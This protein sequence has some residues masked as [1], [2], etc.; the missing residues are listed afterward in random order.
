[1]L[2][3]KGQGF[4]FDDVLLIPRKSSILPAQV[5]LVT[6]LGGGVSLKLPVLSA[7]MDTVTEEAMAIAVAT[8]GG[9]GV[10]HR[11]Q[12]I[13]AQAKQVRIVKRH[14]SGVVREPATT[15][16]HTTIAELRSITKQLG[17]SGMPVVDDDDELV[18]IVTGRDFR[19]AEDSSAPVRSV[20]T[21]RD[22]LV[23]V[24]DG[25]LRAEA[26][27]LMHKN[28]IEKILVVDEDGKL[29]GLITYRDIQRSQSSPEATMDKHER[30]MVAAA[31]GTGD[32]GLQR[33][34]ALVENGVDVLVID[35]AHGHSEGV[36]QQ[37]REIRRRWPELH[38]ISGNVATGDGGKALADAGASAVK[39]GIGPGSICTT[40]MVTGVGVPQITAISDVVE[41]LKDSC[42]VICDGG[43]RY[44]GDIAKA[45]AAGA[46]AVMVGSM[47]AGT[48][49][50]PGK[51]ELYQ[52]RAYKTYR[53][54]GSLGAMEKGVSSDRY[55]QENISPDKLVPE[56]IEGIVPYRSGVE[57]VIHQ[58]AG[59]LKQ[60]MGYLGAPDMATFRKTA[61]FV[62]ITAAGQ[63][64]SHVHDVTITKEPPNYRLG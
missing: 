15:T 10:I 20:M 53:G 60:S 1:M 64:E 11:N 24:S 59:G 37:T 7:A 23:T 16:P 18:G 27:S 38:I 49:E 43:L 47:L 5:S 21:P 26:A 12:T 29:A 61:E 6:S 41:G 50:A 57:E 44:S 17:I 4:T 52:G 62:Q 2:R 63:A 31:V 48:T 35:S 56:G 51:V 8:R 25:T 58:L 32:A 45:L 42:P 28:R 36:I 40:R 13:E 39:V 30:L 22:D 46:A 34:E 14:E 3:L 19:D 54:M 33:A 55:S 9:L